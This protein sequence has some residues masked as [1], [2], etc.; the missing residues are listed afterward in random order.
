MELYKPLQGL[1]ILHKDD[2]KR[3][4]IK[5]I[6][7]VLLLTDQI[8]KKPNVIIEDG[9]KKITFTYSVQEVPPSGSFYV[10][11]PIGT[12]KVSNR[13]TPRDENAIRATVALAIDTFV[14]EEY[15][16]ITRIENQLNQLLGEVTNTIDDN[17]D[18]EMN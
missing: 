1:R 7:N 14:P 12:S 13:E 3:V 16:V 5:S 11:S 2:E 17:G 9:G 10:A 8:L 6:V 4:Y 18:I 15:V